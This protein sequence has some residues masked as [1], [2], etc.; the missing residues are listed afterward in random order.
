MLLFSVKTKEHNITLSTRNEMDLG[1]ILHCIRPVSKYRT[2]CIAARILCR[3][4]HIINI[5]EYYFV[6]LIS[7]NQNVPG[8]EKTLL[9]ITFLV[10]PKMITYGRIALWPLCMPC[11][12]PLTLD[13]LGR[14]L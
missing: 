12:Q 9:G 2:R 14:Y 4:R 5:L 13:F 8:G 11:M 3:M 6:V 1:T 10:L 7:S